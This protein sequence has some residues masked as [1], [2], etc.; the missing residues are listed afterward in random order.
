MKH[1]MILAAVLL[2]VARAGA[3]PPKWQNEATAATC[4]ESFPERLADFREGVVAQQ[5]YM[6]EYNRVIPWFQ[7][8]CR[9]L[10]TREIAIRKLDDPAA[11]VCDTRRGRPKELSSEFALSHDSPRDIATFIEHSEV[12]RWCGPFDRAS[13]ISLELAQAEQPEVE[14]RIVL[15]VMCWHVESPKCDRARAALAGAR[16]PGDARRD[17]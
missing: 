9:W 6:A 3:E 12:N 7:E 17:E 13:R 11:F 15:E 8:H 10:S 16:G 1:M 5:R 2:V 14:A 4:A